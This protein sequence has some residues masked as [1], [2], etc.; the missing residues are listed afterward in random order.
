MYTLWRGKSR[1]PGETQAGEVDG[2]H[3]CFQKY[4]NAQI[5]PDFNVFLPPFL[6]VIIYTISAL[7]NPF[8]LNSPPSTVLLLFLCLYFIP[9]PES[10]LILPKETH[11]VQQQGYLEPVLT[12]DSALDKYPQLKNHKTN[13]RPEPCCVLAVSLL[14]WLNCGQL[15]STG[16]VL[17][18]E[19]KE[20][21]TDHQ[22]N[23]SGQIKGSV[24]PEKKEEKMEN[25]R[26]EKRHVINV[27]KKK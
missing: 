24:G 13:G 10:I 8:F 6:L 12:L 7:I 14:V 11:F 21:K 4:L 17:L 2:N 16:D 23:V 18:Q 27:K 5:D 1:K 15:F 20:K 19:K 3:F 22:R 25:A 9:D 26:K